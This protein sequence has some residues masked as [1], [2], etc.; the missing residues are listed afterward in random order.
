[1]ASDR[2]MLISSF[3]GETVVEP[4]LTGVAA[5]EVVIF[6]NALSMLS[7]WDESVDV[8]S[9]WSACNVTNA[10]PY[11]SQ[12]DVAGSSCLLYIRTD[13]RP[14]VVH[15]HIDLVDDRVDRGIRVSRLSNVELARTSD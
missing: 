15:R 7:I 13:R 4:L 14:R 12:S 9:R 1:M 6:L 5:S 10:Q 11:L 8:L 2:V 3:V